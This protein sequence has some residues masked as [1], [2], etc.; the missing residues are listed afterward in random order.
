[1]KHPFLLV[2]ALASFGGLAQAQQP[3]SPPDVAVR[4][5]RDLWQGMTN[6]VTQ[7]AAEVP[8]SLYAYKPVATVRSFGQLI[9][10]VAGAQYMICAAALGDPPRGED[11]IEKTRTTKTELLAALRASTEYC[12]RAYAQ[13][14]AAA[15]QRTQLFGQE[16]SRLAALGINATHN[17]EHYG[18]L[19]TYMRMNGLVP[20]SSRPPQ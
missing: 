14:D 1:M 2:L 3:A 12:G 15:Q 6:Y 19:V 20:P 9:G 4:T 16:R 17:A 13:T 5:V 8:D 7:A 11:E 10:H 18:N